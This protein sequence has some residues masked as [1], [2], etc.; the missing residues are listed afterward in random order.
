MSRNKGTGTTGVRYAGVGKRLKAF[1][2]DYLVILAYVL[3]LGSVNYGVILAG[4]ALDRGWAFFASPAG[5]DAVAFLTLV[6]PVMLYFA[7]QESSFRQATWG[8]RK[9]KIVVTSLA[10]ERL[11][12]GRALVRSALKFLP[13]QIAH[14]SIYHVEGLPFAPEEPS[15]AVM[16]GFILVYVLVGSYLLSALLSKKHR[17]PYDWAAGSVVI[18]AE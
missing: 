5:K 15:P 18:A 7:L 8:K 3:V 4:G 17:A 12:R 2:L 13:W 1:A 9:A 11:T 16:A 14:T 10:G 6:L